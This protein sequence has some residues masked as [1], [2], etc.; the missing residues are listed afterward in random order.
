MMHLKWK[1]KWR[2]FYGTY[3]KCVPPWS[4]DAHEMKDK[5]REFHGTYCKC[6]PHWSGDAHILEK[7]RGN[8]MKLIINV[9]H[10]HLGLMI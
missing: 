6:V 9:Y 8:F 7:Y 4:G 2:E 10:L 5:L 1:K 3:Y